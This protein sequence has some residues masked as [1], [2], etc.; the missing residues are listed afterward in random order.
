MADSTRLSITLPKE[1]D[2]KL[3]R[4]AGLMN[5]SKTAVV[6]NLLSGTIDAQIAM[7]QA[8]KN[9]KFLENMASY[10]SALDPQKAEELRQIGNVL[11]SE[12]EEDKQ[13][14]DIVNSYFDSLK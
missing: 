7:W 10:L 2:D 4:L 12:K 3:E 8:M 13:K 5:I 11:T 1:L 9:P 6:I 14:V